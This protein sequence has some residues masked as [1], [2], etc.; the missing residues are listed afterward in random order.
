MAI[1]LLSATFLLSH[2]IHSP[3]MSTAP[4]FGTAS[5]YA[6]AF[7][8]PPPKT[9]TLGAETCFNLTVFRGESEVGLLC[10]GMAC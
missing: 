4:P 10:R 8:A 2:P 1:R 7:P 6:D 5:A 3:P 9:L